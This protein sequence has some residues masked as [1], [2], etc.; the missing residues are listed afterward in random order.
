MAT[1]SRKKKNKMVI[2]IEGFLGAATLPE[3]AELMVQLQIG[4][5]M[6]DRGLAL[7]SK[8]HERFDQLG[9][10]QSALADATTTKQKARKTAQ[11]EMMALIMVMRRQFYKDDRTMRLAGLGTTRK[12]ETATN[13]QESGNENQQQEATPEG[14]TN[15]TETNTQTKDKPRKV[16]VAMG[17]SEAEQLTR[18]RSLL[19]KVP[20]LPQEVQDTLL[21]FGFDQPRLDQL[22]AA[23][24]AFAQT[25]PIKAQALADRKE[26]NRLLKLAESDLN[27]WLVTLRSMLTPKIRL[28]ESEGENQFLA[29]LAV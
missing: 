28:L 14:E 27:S 20:K 18:W 21:I 19:T 8:W 22:S 26:R 7:I 17:Q 15:N 1:L 25:I 6:L 3:R 10:A 23:V 11:L 4:Q 24:E 2:T 5:L 16:A 29:L 12:T 9:D 13:G